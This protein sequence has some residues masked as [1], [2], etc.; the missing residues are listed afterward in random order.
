M[1]KKKKERKKVTSES[2]APRVLFLLYSGSPF[3]SNWATLQESRERER[4]RDGIEGSHTSP[5][6]RASPNP[7]RRESAASIRW[8]P[9]VPFIAWRSSEQRRG[10]RKSPLRH[11]ELPQSRSFPGLP[12]FHYFFLFHFLQKMLVWLPMREKLSLICSSINP[13]FLEINARFLYSK[14]KSVS[15]KLNSFA[16]YHLCVCG[17]SVWLVAEKKWEKWMEVKMLNPTMCNLSLIALLWFSWAG[18]TDIRLTIFF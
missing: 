3:T 7:N 1:K 13:F 10:H 6:T 12:R 17:E 4:E 2:R 5:R 18:F 8:F 11:Q 15:I 9:P 16:N 14:L